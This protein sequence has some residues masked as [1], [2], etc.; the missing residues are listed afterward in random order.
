[1]DSLEHKVFLLE[2]QV[3]R[4]QQVLDIL[5]RADS[6]HDDEWHAR[7][8]ARAD[9]DDQDMVGIIIGGYSDE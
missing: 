9:A 8:Q 3:F 4:M 6:A 7:I 2:Q 5:T 1:M